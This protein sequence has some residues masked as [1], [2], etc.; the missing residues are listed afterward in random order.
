MQG[1]ENKLPRSR[2]L[3]K[4]NAGPPPTGLNKR[5]KGVL[6]TS[7]RQNTQPF[8]LN[9]QER[10]CSLSPSLQKKLEALSTSRH[11]RTFVT[12]REPSLFEKY[13]KAWGFK[14]S[15]NSEKI[16]GGIQRISKLIQRRFSKAF[17]YLETFQRKKITVDV[18]HP[19]AMT[20]CTKCGQAGLTLLTTSTQDYLSPRF[21]DKVKMI[22]PPGKSRFSATQPIRDGWALTQS[23]APTEHKAHTP[24][25]LSELYEDG[26]PNPKEIVETSLVMY[27]EDQIYDPSMHQRKLSGF[28]DLSV[29]PFD[30][31]SH[32]GISS[33]SLASSRDIDK[34]IDT[35]LLEIHNRSKMRDEVS[36]EIE[37][38]YPPRLKETSESSRE[39]SRYKVPKLNFSELAPSRLFEVKSKYSNL[40]KPY[41][42]SVNTLRSYRIPPKNLITG[43]D[44]LSNLP[45]KLLK[46]A[47]SKMSNLKS[48]AYDDEQSLT[49]DFSRDL[50]SSRVPEIQGLTSTFGLLEAAK[51]CN[52]SAIEQR[53]TKMLDD[54]FVFD[55]TEP[56]PNI[57]SRTKTAFKIL[58][59]RLD[60]LIYRRKMTGFYRLTDMYSFFK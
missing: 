32:D 34:K 48:R 3:I 22:L 7:N 57:T 2:S 45:K 14:K 50:E 31:P 25:K 27:S 24:K 20:Y 56:V 51:I 54:S 55:Y 36:F 44:K 1:N 12:S 40:P 5:I 23:C 41:Q 8:K 11:N 18:E 28:H 26:S 17:V 13:S 60:K 43:F 6:Q 52:L 47:F 9:L 15:Y 16:D 58:H 29:I 38:A 42:E 37:P 10:L 59:T 35:Q 53:E 39:E 33:P 49:F 21:H 19:V 30:P 4:D 46:T